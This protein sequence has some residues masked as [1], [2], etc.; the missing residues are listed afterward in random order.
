MKEIIG[1][2]IV[3]FSATDH[4]GNHRGADR[5]FQCHRS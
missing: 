5:G 2:L 1:E 4:D 3:D